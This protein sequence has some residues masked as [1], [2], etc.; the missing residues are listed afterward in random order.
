MFLETFTKAFIKDVFF[1]IDLL[2]TLKLPEE[3]LEI[4]EVPLE[5][6][7]ILDLRSVLQ[8]FLHGLKHLLMRVFFGPLTFHDS[9]S[10]GG[11]PLLLHKAHHI[12]AL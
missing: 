10:A 1:L 11:F 3:M 5:L 8:A 6:I 12:S 9:A 2:V 4:L 7:V